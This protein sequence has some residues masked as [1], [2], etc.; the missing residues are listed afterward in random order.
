M[1]LV[2]PFALFFFSSFQLKTLLPRVT[3][4]LAVVV[5]RLLSLPTT[6]TTTPHRYW[7]KCVWKNLKVLFIVPRYKITLKKLTMS[8]WRDVT[9]TLLLQQSILKLNISWRYLLLVL[10]LLNWYTFSSFSSVATSRWM[11]RRCCS[12]CG[13]SVSKTN[14]QVVQSEYNARLARSLLVLNCLHYAIS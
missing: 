7:C 3:L 6:V 5:V 4:S 1:S 13:A 8:G 11:L 2:F 14:Q 9:A 10:Q 12:D